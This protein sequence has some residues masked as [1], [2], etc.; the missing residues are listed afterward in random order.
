MSGEIAA[1]MAAIRLRCAY[2]TV[3]RLL[4]LGESDSIGM[5]LLNPAD[6]WGN[7]IPVEIAN[8]TGQL[9]ETVHVRFY[10]WGEG[11]MG[12]LESVLE[13]GPYDAIVIST[14]KVGFTIFSADNRVRKVLGNRAGDWFKAGVSSFDR[15]TRR[16]QPPGLK[17]RMNRLTHKAARR[18]IGQ[19]PVTS[20]AAV[21]DGYVQVFSRLAQ[22]EDVHVVVVAAPPIP[23]DAAKRRPNLTRDVEWFRT[24]MR[25]D[26]RR[27]HF[28]HFDTES[29]LPP[30]GPDRDALFTDA[31]HKSPALHA[32]VGR[33]VAELV[34]RAD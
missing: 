21:A 27:R 17:L 20:A 32:L 4:I 11:T 16:R 29:I 23:S 30:P 13:R 34:V 15:H 6:A 10:S 2:D 1:R 28:A 24:R 25:D 19:G 8:L 33:A 3:V 9:P 31:V 14:T 26:A 12:F 22:L 5:A 7:R 18:L